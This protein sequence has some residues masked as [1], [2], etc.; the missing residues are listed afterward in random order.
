MRFRAAPAVCAVLMMPALA[1]CTFSGAG[2]TV[3]PS[4]PPASSSPVAA[5]TVPPAPAA[6]VSAEVDPADMTTWTITTDGIGPIERGADS[7]EVVGELAS[8]QASEWCPGVVGLERDGAAQVVLSL[9]E[10]GVQISNVWVSSRPE[11]RSASPMTEEGIRLGASTAELT[12]AYP[13]LSTVVQRGTDTLVYAA[14]SDEGG[15]V[16][17]VIDDDVVVL[18]GASDRPSAPKEWCG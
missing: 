4:L 3:S 12:T 8:F 15:W 14:G 11:D 13:D 18:I 16:D 7:A 17:F 6:S 2:A 5:P 10:D 9:A 1:G